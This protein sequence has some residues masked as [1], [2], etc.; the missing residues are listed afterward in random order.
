MLLRC[1]ACGASWEETV[2]D[3][4]AARFDRE[5]DRAE[6][7]MRR[8][9]DRLAREALQDQA[10]AFAVALELDLIGADDFS[11]GLRAR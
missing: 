7:G 3:E 8:L 11:R 4:A 10:D 1:G 9:A 2:S 5:L 6:H